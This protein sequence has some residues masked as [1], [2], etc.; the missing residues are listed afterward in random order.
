MKTIN[1]RKDLAQLETKIANRLS[2]LRDENKEIILFDKNELGNDTPDTY[3]EMRN[4]NTGNV[5]DV[6]VLEITDKGILVVESEDTEKFHT[7]GLYDLSST[8][9]K[10][11]LIELI[12][13]IK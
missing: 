4:D 13:E 10:I 5:F 12:E 6:F 2:E 1:F 11:N 7:I 3:F 8:T 9:D